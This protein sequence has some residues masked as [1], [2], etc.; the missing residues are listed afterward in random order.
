MSGADYEHSVFFN[1]PFDDDYKALSDAIIFAIH[2]CGYIARS[3]RESRDGSEVRIDKICSIIADCKFGIHDISRTDLDKTNSLPRFNMP[4]ELGLFLG[5]K[6]FG[7]EEQKRKNCLIL[8][9][10]RYRFGK[11]ISDISG[12]DPSA[13]NNDPDEAIRQVRDW[14]REATP[15]SIKMPGATAMVN[16]YAAFRV[17]LP[18][19]CANLDLEPDR[20][21]F[22]EYAMIVE[23]WLKAHP[24]PAG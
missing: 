8:D 5:A 22:N 16:R 18:G 14:L 11:F 12:Q 4:L 23:E 19:A 3:A 7:A 2:D 17:A 21:T 9:T 10:E 20:L 13:H 6:R 15:T 24:R 1:C